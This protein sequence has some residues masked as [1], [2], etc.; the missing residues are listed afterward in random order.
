MNY[1]IRKSTN[2]DEPIIWQMLF[3]AS[4]MHEQDG[5]TL[6][7]AKHDEG[8]AAYAKNWG[9]EGDLGYIAV[10][11]SGKALGAAWVRLYK[12]ENTSYSQVDD[13]TPELSIAVLP[14]YTGKGIGTALMQ[15]LLADLKT[16]YPAVMLNVRADNPALRLYQR[17][18]F[19]SFREMTNRVGTLSY[20][21]ILR[22]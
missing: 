12:G 3:Y 8:V 6:E 9:R 15:K 14:D 20:D 5:K 19:Q 17:L 18:G 21:M 2:D 10:D 16:L 11:D 22:F 13:N 1:T 7:D 4:H